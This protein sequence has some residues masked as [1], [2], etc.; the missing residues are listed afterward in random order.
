MP[1]KSCVAC[2]KPLPLQ[3]GR[4]R[5]R[6]RCESCA[7]PR[8]RKNPPSTRRSVPKPA[9]V[10]AGL[11]DATKRELSDA[12][13]TD[14]TAGQAALLLA[15]RIEAGLARAACDECA[16]RAG[17]EKGAGLAALVKQH[18][19]CMARAIAGQ[20]EKATDPLDDL[21]RKREERERLSG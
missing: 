1:A 3:S 12:E 8:N 10:V 7:P 2:G 20:P 18:G 9:P 13:A 17:S 21:Q 6:V 14:T 4:G 16:Q 5:R 11:V 15:D 19:E